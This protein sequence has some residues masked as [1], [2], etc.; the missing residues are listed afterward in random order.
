MIVGQG[1]ERR[2]I[3]DLCGCDLGEGGPD[4][5]LL[6]TVVRLRVDMAQGIVKA[7]LDLRVC[8]GLGAG[9]TSAS[10]TGGSGRDFGLRCCRWRGGERDW[11]LGVARLV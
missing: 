8:V 11:R 2:R 7:T 1:F 3:K 5:S 6:G 10:S 4:C 9:V